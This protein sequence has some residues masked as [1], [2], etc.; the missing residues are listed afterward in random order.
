MYFK[1]LEPGLWTLDTG[2]Y[3]GLDTGLYTGLDTGMDTG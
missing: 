3:T 1:V 2:L